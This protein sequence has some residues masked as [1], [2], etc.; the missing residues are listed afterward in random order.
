MDYT[1][2]ELIRFNNSWIK[3]KECKLW[4]KYL[5]R[6]G[7]GTFYFRKKSRRA[8]RVAYYFAKGSIP[9]NMVIDHI[10]KNRNCVEI[11]HLK[12]VTKRENSLGNSNS[13]ASI[14]SRKTHCKNNHKFDRKYGKQRYCSICQ[15]KKAKHLRKKWLKE[16][17]KI[18]C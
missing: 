2:Q 13:V 9:D 10:C 18:K 4:Q 17:N 16:A 1:E 15:S 6:D 14:N 12:L 11:N 5:D 3:N 8:H 7:Y